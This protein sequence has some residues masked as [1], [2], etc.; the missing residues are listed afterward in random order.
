MRDF[1]SWKYGPAHNSDANEFELKGAMSN[2]NDNNPS[3]T[4]AWHANMESKLTW[5]RKTKLSAD[6]DLV[7][8]ATRP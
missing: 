1:G 8:R 2:M 4:D 6:R 3:C 7:D 5:A